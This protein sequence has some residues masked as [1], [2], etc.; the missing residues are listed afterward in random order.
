MTKMFKHD[1]RDVDGAV[2]DNNAIGETLGLM[3]TVPVGQRPATLV[4]AIT[5]LGTDNDAFYVA[6]VAS[7]FSPEVQYQLAFF[8]AQSFSD[9][10]GKL[11]EKDLDMKGKLR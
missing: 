4:S 8:T 3:E 6:K 2:T 7:Y 9:M 10:K 11:D 5:G 1:K